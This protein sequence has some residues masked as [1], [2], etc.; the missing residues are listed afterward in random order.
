MPHLSD[1]KNEATNPTQ[2]CMIQ[3]AMTQKPEMRL[4]V[5]PRETPD[6]LYVSSETLKNLNIELLK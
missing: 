1:E 6:T 5:L 2:G 4:P 3:T